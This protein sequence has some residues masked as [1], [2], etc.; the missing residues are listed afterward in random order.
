[1]KFPQFC[2]YL[3]LITMGK[4]RNADK[5]ATTSINH[6][7]GGS[8]NS[9]FSAFEFNDEDT[10]VEDESRK[11]VA[12]FG[13]KSPRKPVDKYDFLECCKS[14]T[15]AIIAITLFLDANVLN[16]CWMT[17]NICYFVWGCCVQT[18]ALDEWLG[19][20]TVA[21]YWDDCLFF[22]TRFYQSGEICSSVC[23]FCLFKYLKKL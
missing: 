6:A 13:A 23:L 21:P 8:S 11:A 9:K 17:L 10:R 7:G 4:R 3:S 15:R 19:W 14:I 22:I 5:K 16:D 2:I 20:S 1:M 18:R 12:K